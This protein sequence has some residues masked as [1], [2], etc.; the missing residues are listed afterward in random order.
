MI[1]IERCYYRKKFFKLEKTVQ[2][3][4][5]VKFKKLGHIFHPFSFFFA[6]TGK[7][8]RNP[9]QYL[10]ERQILLGFNKR[11]LILIYSLVLALFSRVNGFL[12]TKKNRKKKKKLY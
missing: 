5:Y 2:P 8:E 9:W 3:W 1:N 11:T 7:I 6:L 4:K 12:T 10:V